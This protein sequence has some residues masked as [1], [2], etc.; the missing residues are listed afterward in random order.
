M[1]RWQLGLWTA[2]DRKQ[3]TDVTCKPPTR[4]KCK[5]RLNHNK[6]LTASPIDCP[7]DHICEH[8]FTSASSASAIQVG[9][10]QLTI[11]RRTGKRNIL[12]GSRRGRR[13]DRS[14]DPRKATG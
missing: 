6:R 14:T 1:A 8:L 3:F 12:A 11:M 4:K 2:T 9:P 7:C 13:A 5:P 10:I